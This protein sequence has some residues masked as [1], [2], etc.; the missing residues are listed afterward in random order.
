M[1]KNISRGTADGDA[2]ARSGRQCPWS[3]LD[4][5]RVPEGQCFFQPLPNDGGIGVIPSALS[6]AI[7]LFADTQYSS[8]PDTGIPFYER[9]REYMVG[10]DV[11]LTG[12]RLNKRLCSVRADVSED[13]EHIMKVSPLDTDAYWTL[14]R[15]IQD[16]WTVFSRA[17]GDRYWPTRTS[18]VDVLYNRTH[19]EVR[20]LRPLRFNESPESFA[21]GLLELMR[22]LL[23][24]YYTR[25]LNHLESDPLHMERVAGHVPNSRLR[26]FECKYANNLEGFIETYYCEDRKEMMAKARERSNC[27]CSVKAI[28]DDIMSRDDRMTYVPDARKLFHAITVLLFGGHRDHVHMLL[29]RSYMLD[30]GRHATVWLNLLRAFMAHR[31]ANTATTRNAMGAVV[32]DFQRLYPSMDRIRRAMARHEVKTKRP[33]RI[34]AGANEPLPVV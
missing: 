14:V 9:H 17:G 4:I 29:C 16:R 8:D 13:D 10:D 26:L 1:A 19:G 7:H 23:V 18:A 30:S 11:T 6:N 22:A 33:K 27:S 34:G 24:N 20:A 32:K 15:S 2:A 3:T 12:F 21:R 31:V 5:H 28:M 25:E